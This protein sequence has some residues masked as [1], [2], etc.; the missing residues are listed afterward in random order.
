MTNALSLAFP[1]GCAAGLLLSHASADGLCLRWTSSSMNFN[2]KCFICYSWACMCLVFVANSIYC[3]DGLED[4]NQG[5]RFLLF[6][7][8]VASLS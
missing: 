1:I 4:R 5:K 7:S 6:F 3:F 8:Y 2:V